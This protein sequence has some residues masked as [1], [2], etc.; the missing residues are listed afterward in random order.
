[1]NGARHP[2]V[3]GGALGGHGAV[4]LKQHNDSMGCLKIIPVAGNDGGEETEAKAPLMP[5]KI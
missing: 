5:K 3:L 4:S 2:W 1:M